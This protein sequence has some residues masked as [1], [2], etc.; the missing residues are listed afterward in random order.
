MESSETL[1]SCL[2]LFIF[3]C[4]YSN[5][6]LTFAISWSVRKLFN[7]CFLAGEFFAI[8]FS[9]NF[10]RMNFE[11]GDNVAVIFELPGVALLSE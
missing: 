1:V 8:N 4:S 6:L 11:S 3:V 2:L 10:A 7:N 9:I 5:S